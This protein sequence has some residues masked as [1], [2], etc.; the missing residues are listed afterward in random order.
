[1][2]FVIFHTMTIF[3]RYVNN[4]LVKKLDIFVILYL[5]NILIYTKNLK[6]TNIKINVKIVY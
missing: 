6:K 1:M 5:N 4:I 2:L 3:Q